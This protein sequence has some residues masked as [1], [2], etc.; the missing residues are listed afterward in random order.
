MDANDC[1]SDAEATV[2]SMLFKKHNIVEVNHFFSALETN[3]I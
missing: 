1:F 2:K 3:L